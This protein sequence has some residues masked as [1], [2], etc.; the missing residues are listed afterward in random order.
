MSGQPLSVQACIEEWPLPVPRGTAS[1]ILGSTRQDSSRDGNSHKHAIRAC[2]MLL[3]SL[4]AVLASSRL[5]PS[6]M[7]FSLRISFSYYDD[8]VCVAGCSK[9]LRYDWVSD[10]LP[11]MRHGGYHG[12]QQQHQNDS[13]I[14][15]SS[16]NR[17]DK[18]KVQPLTGSPFSMCKSLP[19]PEPILPKLS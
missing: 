19:L 3:V 11:S 4:R 16:K 9:V 17:N 14:S 10:W 12:I 2:S 8:T 6:P 5:K 13:N 7:S 18:K 15:T 1:R